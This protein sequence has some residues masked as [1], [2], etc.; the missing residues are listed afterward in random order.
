MTEPSAVLPP[1]NLERLSEDL[2]AAAVRAGGAIMR[3]Y[4]RR[5]AT[6]RKSDLSPVTEADEIAESIVLAELARILPDVPVVAEEAACGGAAP[7]VGREF[8]LVDALDGT[9]EFLKRN[10]EFTVNIAL[11]RDGAPV[12][13]VVYA[14]ALGRLWLAGGHA[15]GCAV[16]PDGSLPPRQA[17]SVLRARPRPAAGLVALA[18]RSHRDP[19]TE[20]FLAGLPLT[21]R[22][23]GGSSIKFCLLA[24]GDG[25]V[26]ARLAPTMEWDTAAGDAI[27][28]AA[29]GS[30]EDAAGV[31]LR[32]GKQTEGFRNAGFVAWGAPGVA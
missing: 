18:S 17:R 9:R 22:R 7:N 1:R 28:R 25:D 27:L 16:S 4:G 19:K 15:S 13:G 32:Y 21:A 3:I 30:V 29:G 6:W 20:E 5:C 23:P 26:Y 24:Q 8:A 2:A 14:P 12:C 11:V 10:D 31:P